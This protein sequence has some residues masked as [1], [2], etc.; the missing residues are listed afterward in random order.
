MTMTA[1]RSSILLALTLIALGSSACLKLQPESDSTRF[2]VLPSPT[3]AGPPPEDVADSKAPPLFVA[4]VDL[5]DYLQTP[6]IAIRHSETEIR[7]A[8]HDHWAEPLREGVTRVLQDALNLHGIAGPIHPARFRRPGGSYH[9]L[10]VTLTRFECTA[11]GTA[12]LSARWALVRQP[13]RQPVFSG[14]TTQARPFNLAPQHYGAAVSA[15]GGCLAD[16]ADEIAAQW[17]SDH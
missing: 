17:P 3:M 6:A 2:Y 16:L 9:E 12:V 14:H 15:L 10:E 13:E 7:F 11:D 4:R 1:T 5:P 8:R